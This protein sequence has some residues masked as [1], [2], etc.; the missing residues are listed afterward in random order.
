MADEV[1]PS[2]PSKRD[3]EEEL[4]LRKEAEKTVVE[5]TADVIEKR[6]KDLEE[7]DSQ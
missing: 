3:V 4:R 1:I 5:K 2:V 6:S 7:A